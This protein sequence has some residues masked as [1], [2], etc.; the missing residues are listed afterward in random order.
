M[1]ARLSTSWDKRNRAFL[2]NTRSDEVVV[3]NFRNK[4]FLMTVSIVHGNHLL[5]FFHLS[6]S[7]GQV[8]TDWGWNNTV[9]VRLNDWNMIM[10]WYTNWTKTFT[11]LRVDINFPA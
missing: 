7:L 5:A 11:S 9:D 8:N 1:Y 3:T 6:S 4:D 2:N 10:S